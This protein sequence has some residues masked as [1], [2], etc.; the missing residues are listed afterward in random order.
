MAGPLPV[1]MN[2]WRWAAASRIGTSHQRLRTRKQD[3]FNCFLA[4]T[5]SAIIC[6]VV[7]D[8]A[9]SA[10]LG[11]QG[12]SVVCRTLSE[13]LKGHFRTTVEL[14]G[15]SNIWAW[16]NDARDR[17]ACAA[18]SRSMR[19]QNFASTLVMLVASHSRSVV[20]HI[21]DGSV[22]ARD[23]AGKWETLSWPENGEYAS[24]TYFVTDDPAPRLRIL[25]LPHAYDAYA[26]FTDGIEDLAL[27]Q[28]ARTPHQPFFGSMIRPLDH[29]TADGKDRSLS[30]AL[31]QFLESERV[32]GRTDDDKSLI[33]A[34][35]A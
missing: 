12:A 8:G 13:S 30:S 33:L 15:A 20:A 16:I 5:D 23:D 19:R 11:G 3:A 29:S 22:V 7:T 14:P 9:G 18:E 21:G 32:C 34:S 24:T 28:V 2:R 31:G 26:L 27:D 6:A 35:A 25:E 1:D 17:L 10:E 4:P